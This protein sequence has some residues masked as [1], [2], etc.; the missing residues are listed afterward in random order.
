MNTKTKYEVEL[1]TAKEAAE[2]V[3]EAIEILRQ[4][5]SLC[6][7]TTAATYN[8]YANELEEVLW[9]DRGQSGL[10]PFIQ[11]RI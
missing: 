9:T 2:K 6:S 7:P 10:V 8:F 4:F 3:Q 11:S 1:H 5:G